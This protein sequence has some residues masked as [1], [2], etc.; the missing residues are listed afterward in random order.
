VNAEED[1]K[2]EKTRRDI[3]DEL[4]ALTDDE[5]LDIAEKDTNSLRSKTIQ[6]KTKSGKSLRMKQEYELH[7]RDEEE[8]WTG[9]YYSFYY[10]DPIGGV[11]IISFEAF[12]RGYSEIV[13]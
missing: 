8:I 9:A 7:I 6:F 11:E 4:V 13:V 12:K 5:K 3:W 1:K 10:L 2:D